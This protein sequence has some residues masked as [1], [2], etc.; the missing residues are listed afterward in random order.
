MFYYNRKVKM[1]LERLKK[2]PVTKK[3]PKN[4]FLAHFGAK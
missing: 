1:Q 2:N 4:A 3:W